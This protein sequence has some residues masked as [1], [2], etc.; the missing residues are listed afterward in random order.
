MKNTLFILS[1][2]MCITS[3]AQNKKSFLR[4]GNELYTDSS[5]NDAE[6]QYRKS[7][8]KDQDYFNASFNLADAVYKQERYEESSALFDALIDNAPTENALAKVYHNLGN[9]LTQEQKLE[10]AIEAYKNA[11]RINP[12]DAETRHNLALS[13]KQKQEQEQQEEKK[14]ENKEEKKD[15]EKDKE[16]EDKQ[17]QNKEQEKEDEE[18]E[19]QPEEKK[20]EMSKEDAEKMLE[21]IQ[22]EEKELQEELQKKKVKGKRVKVLK[23]W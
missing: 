23:D 17:E 9:S 22:Q 12:N 19:N 4:D 3:F 5:Y 6:M 2:L 11:L 8:E 18:K 1:L 21:A 20:E 15:Q 7:L 13:K 10:E 16:G 14:E